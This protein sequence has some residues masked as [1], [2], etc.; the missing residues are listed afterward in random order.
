MK[1]TQIVSKLCKDHKVE[2]PTYS[3][4][5]I[6]RF[7]G[8][9]WKAEKNIENEQGL[10]LLKHPNFPGRLSKGCYDYIHSPYSNHGEVWGSFH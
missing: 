1:P 5:G 8:F 10:C 6:V 9:S 4:D 2:P 7:S 3:R